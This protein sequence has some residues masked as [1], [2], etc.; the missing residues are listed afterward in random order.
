MKKT[1]ALLGTYDKMKDLYYREAIYSHNPY[2]NEVKHCGL[3]SKYMG[4]FNLLDTDKFG[5]L[6]E[7]KDTLILNKRSSVQEGQKSVYEA[8]A[9]HSIVNAKNQNGTYISLIDL[10]DLNFS[11]M[12]KDTY[13]DDD[14]FGILMTVE[15]SDDEDLILAYQSVE[16]LSDGFKI[17]LVTANYLYPDTRTNNLVVGDD[18]TNKLPAT[19]LYNVFSNDADVTNK[20]AVEGFLQDT[21]D[22]FKVRLQSASYSNHDDSDSL[23]ECMDLIQLPS[24]VDSMSDETVFK[25]ILNLED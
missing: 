11:N 17:S 20:Q 23:F 6:P 9:N 7:F 25:N 8:F 22:I 15:C 19:I 5:L 3:S 10:P 2:T 12:K 24:D 4:G 21:Q 18:I 14:L 13:T 16:K 1:L